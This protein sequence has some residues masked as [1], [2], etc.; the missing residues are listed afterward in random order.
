MMRRPVYCD[1]LSQSL[2]PLAMHGMVTTPNHLATQAGLDILRRG[3]NA[4]DAAIASAVTLAVV[5]PPM[6]TPGGYNFGLIYDAR[7]G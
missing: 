5:Y 6:C 4:V 1:T 2:N 3:G 7:A